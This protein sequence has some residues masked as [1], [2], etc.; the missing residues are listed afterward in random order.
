MIYTVFLVIM[1]YNYIIICRKENNIMKPDYKFTLI[2]AIDTDNEKVIERTEENPGVHEFIDGLMTE[3]FDN[4]N[5]KRFKVKEYNTYVIKQIT[6]YIQA[7]SIPDDSHDDI[8]TRYLEAEIIGREAAERLGQK[9]K[10]GYL[11][12][13]L[14]SKDSHYYYILSKI[15]TT[16]FLSEIDFTKINGMPFADKALKSCLIKFDED[17]LLEDIYILDKNDSKYWHR[18]FLDLQEYTTDELS[19]KDFYAMIKKKIIAK[20]RKTP[21]D[22]VELTTHLNSYFSQPRKFTLDDMMENVFNNYS[23]YNPTLFD[24]EKL[25]NSIV[26]AA[27][28]KKLNTSFQIVPGEI[29]KSFN[30]KLKINQF[31]KLEIDMENSDYKNKVG[32]V[33]IH[34]KKYLAIQIDDPDTFESFNN[35]ILRLDDKDDNKTNT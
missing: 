23:P 7:E 32:V 29:R 6:D 28:E 13:A 14:L 2:H 15:E 20:A 16:S 22:L 18:D 31:V 11:F 4:K 35:N 19:T 5:Y 26:S 1:L 33:Y 34:S 25:K 27:I 24:V 17:K 10:M 9:V 8:A 21:T 12:Q 30:T 3:V